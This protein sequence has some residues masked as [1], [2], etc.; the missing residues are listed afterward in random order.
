MKKLLTLILVLPLF[1]K[2][3]DATLNVMGTAG[4]LYL[5]HIAAAKE[6]FYSVGRLYNISP[7]EIAPFNNVT[8]EKG[9]T[10]GQALKI[11]LKEVN[12]TQTNVVAQ[13]EVAV[14]IY[15]KVEAKENLYQIS[16]RFTKVPL[17]SLKAWN[18]LSNETVSVG[19]NIV[20]GYLKVKKDLSSLA[21][22]STGITQAD[23]A[24]TKVAVKTTT[25]APEKEVDNTS[26]NNEI[27]E[28]KKAVAAAAKKLED[29]VKKEKA[30][31]ASVEKA[32]AEKT[33]REEAAA[34]KEAAEKLAKEEAAEKAENEKAAKLEATRLAAKEA[35]A[36]TIKETPKPKAPVVV[37][38]EPVAQIEQD[39][40]VS[41]AKDFKGG[42]FKADF[43]SEGELDNG[44]AGV[45]KST[46][47]WEDGKYYCLY[48]KAQQHT[49]IKITNKTTGKFIYA[50]VLDVMPDLKQNANVIVRVSNAAADV[51][52]AGTNSF[53]CKIEY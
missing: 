51:L 24:P 21:T 36:K 52:G 23:E 8:L 29:A 5:N 26:A 37:K 43:N 13:D 2:A 16:T 32:N 50:K 1:A 19:Q 42:V 31:K 25:K 12:F 53:D 20:I 27:E 41:N 10:I 38:K 17:A 28:A 45:F 3:Q 40:I 44:N 7:K 33:A 34:E 47:G 9:L 14:P 49:I 11:P 48:N 46:S 6:S 39:E 30:A 4:N 15:H 18:N 35:A 22:R